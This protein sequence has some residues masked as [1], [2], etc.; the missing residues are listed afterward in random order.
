MQEVTTEAGVVSPDIFG[1]VTQ[2]RRQ[3]QKDSNFH[4]TDW[5]TQGN[6]VQNLSSLRSI[7]ML[8]I[9]SIHYAHIQTDG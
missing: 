3:A 9:V 5:E 6:I 8:R 7:G 4:F 2:P 1:D